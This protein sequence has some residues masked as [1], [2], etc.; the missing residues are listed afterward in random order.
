MIVWITITGSHSCDY[1]ARILKRKEWTETAKTRL[2]EYKHPE[3]ELAGVS[4]LT[5]VQHQDHAG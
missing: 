5:Y 4:S 2:C 1:R 3:E